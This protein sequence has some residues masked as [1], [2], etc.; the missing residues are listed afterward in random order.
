MIK[1][2]IFTR[3]SNKVE[4]L[5]SAKS[6]TGWL[7]NS[8]GSSTSW[9]GKNFLR[10]NEI[11]LYVNRAIEKRA[12]KIGQTQFVLFE[13]D[14]QIKKHWILDLLAK[15][16]RFHTG[17]AFFRLYQKYKDLTGKAFIYKEYEREIFDEN[18]KIKALHLLRPDR[19]E[20]VFNKERTDID[21]FIYNNGREKVKYQRD[22]IIYSFNPDPL[23]PLE[24]V[25][26]LKPGV[27][28]IETELQ[29]RDYHANVLKNGGKIE[30]VIKFKTPRL[31]KEQI[32][33]LKQSYIEQYAGAKKAG[34]PL[35]LGGDSDIVKVG[36]TPQELAFLEAK[37]MSLEDICI[38]TGVPKVLLSSF[39]DIKFDNAD[40]AE[41]IFQR[42][43][44]K[45]LV[46]DL[47]SILDEHLAPGNVDLTYIDQTPQDIAQKLNA[48]KVGFETGTLTPNEKRL[49]LS[50]I[51]EGI[52]EYPDKSADKLYQPFNLIPISE[53]SG[54]EEK[55]YKKDFEHPLRNKEFRNKYGDNYTKKKKGEEKIFRKVVKKYFAEQKKRILDSL[56]EEK[57]LRKK[58]LLGEMFDY[59]LEISLFENTILPVIKDLYVRNASDAME[60]IGS[61]YS[62]D[63]GS[64]AQEWVSD[65]ANVL[66]KELNDTTLGDLA[67]AIS[68][69]IDQGMSRQDLIKR[70]DD[71]YDGY[72]KER[73]NLIA[74][75]ETHAIMNSAKMEGYKQADVPI[76]IWV[77]SGSA[78]PRDWHQAIDGEE[79]PLNEPFSIGLMYPGDGGPEDSAN[80]GC[81]I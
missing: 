33:E 36:L 9:D 46:E 18:T 66:G 64:Y 80:C 43:T 12:E 31:T 49:A 29:I 34:T 54:T 15:P 13:G 41:A 38:L 17:D 53:E 42:E 76:K 32:E 5:I 6:F 58:N 4:N 23:S 52:G 26:I 25:S 65:R 77:H 50:D 3:I 72:S 59:S 39:Q 63:Y 62:F 75:T 78:N 22:Q 81:T 20:I 27:R 28:A 74:R 70:L 40:A 19:V 67:G 21:E 60:L 2:N 14:R 73:L 68:D 69:T 44:I 10:A 24:G 79:K 48:I 30:T 16:N 11:S 61:E 71:I 37:G 8:L 35:F 57:S 56:G 47:C 51:I 45:P 55:I 7:F 1:Q